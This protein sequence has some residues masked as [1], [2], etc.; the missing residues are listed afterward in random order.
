M[1]SAIMYLMINNQVQIT[2][3]ITNALT[4][5]LKNKKGIDWSKKNMYDGIRRPDLDPVRKYYRKEIEK[6]LEKLGE[7]RSW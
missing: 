1:Y 5:N 3:D 2:A 6:W 4:D 7:T